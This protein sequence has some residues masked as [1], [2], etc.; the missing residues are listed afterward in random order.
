MINF[1]I[2][3]QLQR[4]K[5][6]FRSFKESWKKFP[7]YHVGMLW[8]DSSHKGK[9]LGKF[10]FSRILSVF[11]WRIYKKKIFLRVFSFLNAPRKILFFA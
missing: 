2:I 7:K 6:L 11:L 10:L 8:Q 9:D 4:K 1:L 5:F 3:Q